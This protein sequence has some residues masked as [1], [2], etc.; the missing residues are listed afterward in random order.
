M[1][2]KKMEMAPWQEK[3]R[4]YHFLIESDGSDLSIT[5]SD[6]DGVEIDSAGSLIFPEGFKIVDAKF[7]IN[8]V[9]TSV[10]TFTPLYVLAST[11]EQIA[12]AMPDVES[13]DYFDL[14]VFGYNN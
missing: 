5:T 9:G 14:W 6:L 8:C 1:I 12:L 7:C 2:N 10:N 11:D 4:W 13:C 3:G